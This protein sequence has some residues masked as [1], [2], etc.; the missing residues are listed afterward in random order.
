MGKEDV[1]TKNV[2][3]KKAVKLSQQLSRL[4]L[5][6]SI[7][8]CLIVGYVIQNQLTNCMQ[9]SLGNY[10]GRVTTQLNY[11]V[12]YVLEKWEKD[13]PDLIF[14]SEAKEY[15]LNYNQMTLNEKLTKER[16]VKNIFDEYLAKVDVEKAG[17]IQFCNDVMAG[18]HTVIGEDTQLIDKV[19]LKTN[20]VDFTESS[21][22]KKI[23]SLSGKEKVWFTLDDIDGVILATRITSVETKNDSILLYV[24]PSSYFDQLFEMAKVDEAIPLMVIDENHKII[25]SSHKELIGKTTK[26]E[27]LKHIEK[28]LND[29]AESTT[30][31]EY[32]V[33]SY[34]TANNGWKIVIDA[35]NTILMKDL[36]KAWPI[37]ILILAIVIGIIIISSIILSK[38]IS[39]PLIIMN[40]YM[41]KVEAGELDIENKLRS[42]I[43]TT[44]L[45]IQNLLGGFCNMVRYL[46]DIIGDAKTVSIKIEE[47]I[48]ILEEVAGSTAQSATG[49]EESINSIAVGAQQQNTEIDSSL[50]AMEEL[51]NDINEINNRINDIESSA[52]ITL[53]K[54]QSANTELNQLINQTTQSIAISQ[55]INTEVEGLGKEA[56]NITNIIGLIK[57]ISDQT[58]LLA[59]NAS[60]EAARA[61]NAGKGFA[62]VAEEIRKLSQETQNA[63]K[64]IEETVKN[65]HSKKEVTLKQVKLAGESFRRQLP[66]VESA[67]NTFKDIKE[68]MES[69]NKKIMQT[70]TL[71]ERA[72]KQ[73]DD[74]CSGIQSISSV[75]EEA[76]SASEEV[77]AESVQQTQYSKEI[78]N[79]AMKLN[80]SMGELKAAYSKFE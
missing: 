27:S 80:S 77:S 35:P 3:N 71:L 36:K 45:E 53:S 21:I 39:K 48:A 20:T 23:K 10:S 12:N 1:K 37:I 4:F 67:E 44:S 11:N 5:I 52:K 16:M 31:N 34:S 49:I 38:K 18:K 72:V 25:L 55:N 61:G 75:I 30:I 76:A 42:E 63:I 28:I 22:Y 41:N 73:K 40:T 78:S 46:K 54:S 9:T 47:N 62:V 65:I 32:G 70:T 15:A 8:A 26:D 56:S 2:K 13:T 7:G 64:I 43:N 60:I 59:L 6:I 79:M 50:K 68:E 57:G 17:V 14:N 33:I 29:T 66:I 69:I 58:N 19:V 51:S 24:F 74:V